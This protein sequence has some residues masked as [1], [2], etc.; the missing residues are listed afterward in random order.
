MGSVKPPTVPWYPAMRQPARS[1]QAAKKLVAY[2]SLGNNQRDQAEQNSPQVQ[3]TSLISN[4]TT[5][6]DQEESI[7]FFENL[8]LPIKEEKGELLIIPLNCICGLSEY[9]CS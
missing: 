7:D 2:L 8:S 5:S 4:S 3:D 1:T 9:Y 6:D